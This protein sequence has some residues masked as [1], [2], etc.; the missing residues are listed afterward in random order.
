MA[1]LSTC[2]RCG[3]AEAG[4]PDPLGVRRCL[5]CRIEYRPPL[6]VPIRHAGVSPAKDSKGWMAVF[7]AAG[8]VVGIT[9]AAGDSQAPDTSVPPFGIPELRLPE[10]QVDGLAG[11]EGL[12]TIEAM[13]PERVE[14]EHE[15]HITR[16]RGRELFMTGL[17]RN[18][19]SEDFERVD[20]ELRA[21]DPSGS[22]LATLE[23]TLACP[24]MAA[25]EVC[26]W[27]LD[28]E[29]DVQVSEF[30]FEL[31]GVRNPI[32]G[33]PIVNFRAHFDREGERMSDDGAELHLAPH[34]GEVELEL[35]P[36]TSLSSAWISVTALDEHEQVLD[37]TLERVRFMHATHHQE[38]DIP[39]R[40]E[41]ASFVVAVAG[42]RFELGEAGPGEALELPEVELPKIQL[43]KIELPSRPVEPG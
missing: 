29:L 38:L 30:E 23:P 3:S 35:A 33:L 28:T 15:V 14:L 5:A 24:S 37:V 39:R 32:L 20:F 7:V 43:P 19:S 22:V 16:R 6:R 41:A 31:A 26:A 34:A 1:G 17:V 40:A 12:D 13:M 4:S 8:V 42:Q 9:I 27:A 2:P 25:D 36:G 11:L 10:L 21:L 18:P